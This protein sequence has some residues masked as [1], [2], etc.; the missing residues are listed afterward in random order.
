MDDPGLD[1]GRHLEALLA[2][3]R[4]NWISF[5][6]LRVWH[7]VQRLHAER[8]DT[9]RVLDVACG[10]GDVLRDVARRAAGSGISVE[11]H[12]CD[13]SSVALEE[14]RRTIGDAGLADSIDLFKLDAL[15]GD[16][17][18]GYCL[19]TSS[20]FLHHLSRVDAVS[21]LNRMA[22]ATTRSLLIQDLRR[23]RLGYLF[24]WVGLHTLTR[25][26]VAR[27]DG[28]RS[29]LGAFSMDEIRKI[30]G[31]AGLSSAKVDTGWPQRF[32]IGWRRP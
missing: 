24:A 9:V 29:V 1:R 28:L 13:I 26:D 27:T 31:D 10:G 6:G 18:E 12:G 32:T 19:I 22:A 30:C 4:I 8:N 7:E 23:T 17:P 5:G 21:L 2:L 15:E 25:S 3:E 16:L 20:L 14:G 11:L